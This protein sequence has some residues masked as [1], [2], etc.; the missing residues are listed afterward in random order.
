M[1][2]LLGGLVVAGIAFLLTGGWRTRLLHESAHYQGVIARTEA[3]RRKQEAE[4]RETAALEEQLR[5][6][7]GNADL[8]LQLARLRWRLEGPAAAAVV[9]NAA[10]RPFTDPRVPQQLSRCY[11]LSRREDQALAALNEGIRQFPRDGELRADRALLYLF[12]AWHTEAER[13]IQAA[14]ALKAPNVRTAR[15]ALAR[16]AGDARGARAALE[17]ELQANPGDGEATR[18]LAAVLQKAGES[19][20]AIRLLRSLDP[21]EL[22]PEDQVSLAVLDLDAKDPAR[23]GHALETLDAVIAARP[24]YVRARFLRARCLRKLQRTAE[25]R[26]ELERLVQDF[27]RMSGPS[28]ELGEIYRQDGRSAEATAL[29]RQHQ[30]IQQQRTAFQQAAT[31]LRRYPTNAAVHL[32]MASLL[33]ERGMRGRAIVELERAVQ[34]QPSLNKAKSLLE[35]ARKESDAAPTFEE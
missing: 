18:Q 16:A 3:D 24:D 8:R 31:D 11:R 6:Q 17:A 12:F 22:T 1:W 10:P 21:T 19:E 23:A 35:K 9:L 29:F 28:Y 26:E 14:E 5:A 15:A 4:A 34:L 25:A 20:E 2:L 30:G 13:E 7:P 33:L 32:R 27:P